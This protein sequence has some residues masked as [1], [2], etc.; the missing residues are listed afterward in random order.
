MYNMYK[1]SKDSELRLQTN[2]FKQIGK[3]DIEFATNI[4]QF[5]QCII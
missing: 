3:S 4:P 2:L 1:V 5:D